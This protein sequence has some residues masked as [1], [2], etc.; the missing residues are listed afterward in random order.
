MDEASRALGASRAVEDD[1]PARAELSGGAVGYAPPRRAIVPLSPAVARA[2]SYSARRAM[3]DPASQLDWDDF[4]SSSG[5]GTG[6]EA[7]RPETGL[8]ALV[9]R[10][11][12]RSREEAARRLDQDADELLA[13]ELL[14]LAALDPRW[15]FLQL[16]RPDSGLSALRHMVVGPGG[17]FLLDAKNHPGA[18]LFVE[19][20]TFLVNGRD[21][22]YVS[23]SRLQAST[24]RTLLSRDSGLDLGV[25]GIIVPIKD[26]RLTIQQ[27][28]DDVEVIE[29]NGLAEWLLNQPEQLAE[30]EVVR[31]FTVARRATSR[32]SRWSE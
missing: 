24:A 27:A 2:T 29:R 17:V 7:Q 19:G 9:D 18:K 15:G 5:S 11:L 16:V 10:L 30:D 32:R 13:Q 14:R 6:Y 28:P 21:R 1:P 4:L 26:R 25:T 22:P 31:G 12:G 23:F 20:D 3:P 8:R